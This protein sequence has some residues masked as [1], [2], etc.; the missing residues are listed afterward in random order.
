MLKPLFPGYMFVG[1]NDKSAP[2]QNINNTV[3]VSRLVNNFHRPSPLPNSLVKG[4]MLRCDKFGVLRSSEK[5]MTGDSV[6]LLTGPF[7]NFIATVE[8]I[9]STKRIWVIMEL[10]GQC[11][12][13]A[14][15]R[16]QL[17]TA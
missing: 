14:V 6:E 2:W 15:S 5:L 7:A 10:M 3:G 9:E 12:R 4:L 17:K 1:V 16:E 13:L 11:A 8:T